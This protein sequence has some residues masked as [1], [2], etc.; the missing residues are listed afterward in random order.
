MSI[1]TN[2]LAGYGGTAGSASEAPAGGGVST[3]RAGGDFSIAAV[4]DGV[5][6]SAS[7]GPG[8][9]VRKVGAVDSTSA[10]REHG[11]TS[12]QASVHLPSCPG[13]GTYRVQ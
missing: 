10:M 4:G 11:P 3:E 8:V 9:V 13:L 5:R 2:L 7:V 1:L 6:T 12:D